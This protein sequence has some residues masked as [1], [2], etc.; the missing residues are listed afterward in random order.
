MKALKSFL[1]PS[2]AD[3]YPSFLPE[4]E[5]L[6]LFR[7]N[8]VL[9]EYLSRLHQRIQSEQESLHLSKGED[10]F[11]TKKGRILGLREACGILE[12]L[13]EEIA[14]KGGDNSEEPE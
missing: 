10:K 2:P 13:S 1:P 9:R 8:L 11:E 4:K 3:L 6:Y 5:D 12:T 7:D 14:A